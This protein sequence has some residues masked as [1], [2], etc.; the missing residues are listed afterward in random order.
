MHVFFL[1]FFFVFCFVLFFSF[2]TVHA[3]SSKALNLNL[4]AKSSSSFEQFFNLSIASPFA[5]DCRLLIRNNS[6]RPYSTKQMNQ[7]TIAVEARSNRSGKTIIQ[8]LN[9]KIKSIVIEY[10]FFFWTN[11]QNQI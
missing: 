9:Y 7:P 2:F 11:K 4:Y 3:P 8:V 1:P 10:F 5:T 6:F